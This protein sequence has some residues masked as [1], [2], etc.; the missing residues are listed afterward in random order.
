[1]QR[2]TRLVHHRLSMDSATGGVSIP[3]HQSVVFA[4]ESLEQPGEY[5][6][7]RSG[8]P[9]R[10]ALE[11]AIADLEGGNYGFAF[12]SGM[13]AITA[14]LSLFS[15]GDHL[16]VSQDIYGGTYRA[17][18]SVFKR[19]GLDITFV[20]TTDLETVAA[21]IHPTTKGLYLET[22]SNPLMKI[23]D[24]ARAAALAREHGLITIADN[25]FMTPYL[26]R[27]LEL[28]IDVVVHSATKYL[29][30]HSDCLA[31]LAVTRDAGL[32]RELALL[33]N[34]LGAVLAPHE[35]WLILRGIKT[36]KVRLAQQEQT[37]T[38][39]ATWLA[40]HPQVKA[41]YYPG[42]EGHPGREVHFRQARGAGGVLSFRLATPELARQVINKVRLPVI[43][44]SLGAVESIITL[45]A[46]MSHGSLPEEFKHR[47]GI[48][49]DLVRLS[50]GLEDAGDLKAD[51]EQA[52]KSP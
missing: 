50:V 51:L 48:T 24:L 36:L 10:R 30:G 16:L 27:P 46:T 28:G 14:A 33:Q 31:G 15:A 41:V 1:M 5:E 45:P 29:G 25:T 20:D 42:L 13:A 4:Q 11:E 3:I 9:T 39:L 26:Q 19:F 32:G 22:P 23:T 17:L 18:T 21:Q 6:Y 12:A 40:G 7:T 8:N 47:L 35:C 43:G 2:G 34:T 49:P 38:A 52:L 37:A 44:S